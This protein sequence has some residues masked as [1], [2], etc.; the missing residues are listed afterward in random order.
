V[1]AGL[2]RGG[3]QVGGLAVMACWA[4]VTAAAVRA[5]RLGKADGLN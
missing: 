2:Q 4:A 3:R 5:A 1:L